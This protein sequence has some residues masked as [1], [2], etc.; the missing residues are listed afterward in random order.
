MSVNVSVL[1]EIFVLYSFVYIMTRP[2]LDSSYNGVT[3]YPRSRE[4]S[5]LGGLCVLESDCEKD[6]IVHK[7]GLCPDRGIGVECCYEVIPR[8]A[9]CQKLGGVCMDQCGASER[10]SLVN[11]CGEKM[12]CIRNTVL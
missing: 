11:V 2:Y 10:Q 1:S 6:N 8:Q 9:P 12:C 4:C 5:M 7:R 3:V